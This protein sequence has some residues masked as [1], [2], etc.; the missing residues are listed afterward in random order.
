MPP[1]RVGAATI[2]GF[3]LTPEEH[4][5]LFVVLGVFVSLAGIRLSTYLAGEF[6]ETGDAV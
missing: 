3:T 1:M 2:R 4:L 5:A 6:E